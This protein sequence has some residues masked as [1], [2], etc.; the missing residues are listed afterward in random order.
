MFGLSEIFP[1]SDIY[2]FSPSLNVLKTRLTTILE[3]LLTRHNKQNNKP[4]HSH[5][6][7]A[8]AIK[9]SFKHESLTL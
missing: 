5:V 1:L 8:Q 7:E 2:Y 9:A 4:T 3:L 6:V